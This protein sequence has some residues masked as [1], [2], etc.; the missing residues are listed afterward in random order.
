M[1]AWFIAGNLVV[2]IDEAEGLVTNND[3]K[4]HGGWGSNGVR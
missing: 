1:V 4:Y 2:D 3:V